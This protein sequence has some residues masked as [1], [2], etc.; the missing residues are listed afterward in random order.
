MSS[1][2]PTADDLAA[3]IPDDADSDEA[4]AI[5]VAVSAHLADRERAA[6]DEDEPSWDGARWRFAGRLAALGRRPVRVSRDAPTDPWS[7]AGR[8]DRL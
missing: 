2:Q 5:A 4:A 3:A 7:A 1:G 6:A 8:A